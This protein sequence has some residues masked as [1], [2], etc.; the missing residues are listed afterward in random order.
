MIKVND[1]YQ[2]K[3]EIVDYSIWERNNK[4]KLICKGYYRTLSEAVRA[5]I[6]REAQ[7]ST[8][9]VLVDLESAISRLQRVEESYNR[10]AEKISEGL[11]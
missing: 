8:A 2:I 1:K 3:E 5:I 6:N 4:G 7:H 9:N 11:K 10:L